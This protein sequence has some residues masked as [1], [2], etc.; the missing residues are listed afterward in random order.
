MGFIP[1]VSSHKRLLEFHKR[2]HVLKTSSKF[3]LLNAMCHKRDLIKDLRWWNRGAFG[4]ISWTM[5]WL[6][7]RISNLGGNERR[8]LYFPPVWSPCCLWASRG[9]SVSA[10][11]WRRCR[12]DDSQRVVFTG[13][14]R[15]GGGWCLWQGRTRETVCLSMYHL[16]DFFWWEKRCG[17]GQK[18]SKERRDTAAVLNRWVKT[19][20]WLLTAMTSNA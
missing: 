13:N 2:Q 4:W 18:H 11:Q 16:E 20:Q 17:Q 7:G 10:W 14:V 8:A 19:C 6:T 9:Q 3:S 1:W 5:T 15:T 12:K